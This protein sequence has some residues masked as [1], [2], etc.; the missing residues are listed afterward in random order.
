[1]AVLEGLGFKGPCALLQ[2]PIQS[3][4][5]S[6]LGYGFMELSIYSC[7]FSRQ[8]RQLRSS[9]VPRFRDRGFGLEASGLAA[10]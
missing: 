4:R 9:K 7:C 10:R 1:M 3:Y 6:G 2:G 8:R 5:A